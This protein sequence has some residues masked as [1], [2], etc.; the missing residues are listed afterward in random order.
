MSIPRNIQAISRDVQPADVLVVTKKRSA[1]QI[2]EVI[3]A[4]VK[5]IGENRWEDIQQKYDHRLLHQLRQAGVELHFIGHLQTN[6]VLPVVRSCDVIQTVDSVRLAE[7]IDVVAQ[8]LG[9]IMPVFLQLNLTGEGQKYGFEESGFHSSFQKIQ[10]LEH[11]AVEGLMCMG[12]QGDEVETRKVFR[13]CRELAD[14]LGLKK[15]SM[16]MSGDYR[17][18]VEQGSTMV[19]VGSLVFE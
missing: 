7:K 14:E 4:G 11:V 6:K 19:R 17:I 16:G 15:V 10:M 1:D 9:R 2:R 18:A 12:Q 8:R 13:R 3:Q 5:M